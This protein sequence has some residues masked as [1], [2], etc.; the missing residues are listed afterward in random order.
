MCVCGG[1]GG[2]GRVCVC[3]G[4][5]GHVCVCVWGG[6]GGEGEGGSKYNCVQC[7]CSLCACVFY[8]LCV[9]AY[10]CCKSYTTLKTVWSCGKPSEMSGEIRT[11]QFVSYL[12]LLLSRR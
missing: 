4:G 3:V 6:G 2:G 11:L 1:G 12:H 7:V 10:I 9:H 5:E 8:V